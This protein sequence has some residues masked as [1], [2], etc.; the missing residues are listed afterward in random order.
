MEG[1]AV[2]LQIYRRQVNRSNYQAD[3]TDRK[4]ATDMSACAEINREKMG[5]EEEGENGWRK[6]FLSQR[7]AVVKEPSF[8]VKKKNIQRVTAKEARF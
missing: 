4:T 8:E 1:K 3:L 2:S 6:R 5:G 7:L